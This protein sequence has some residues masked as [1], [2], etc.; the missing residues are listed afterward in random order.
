MVWAKSSWSHWVTSTSQLGLMDSG[1]TGTRQLSNTILLR[2]LAVQWARNQARKGDVLAG[3]EGGGHG[4][5]T[6]RRGPQVSSH[7]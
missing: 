5:P 2:I 6:S 3:D 4:V 1:E 7:L